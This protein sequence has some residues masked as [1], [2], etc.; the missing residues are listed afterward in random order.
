MA[1]SVL[2]P[3]TSESV[4]KPFRSVVL[5]SYS[6]LSFLDLT[7]IGFESQALWRPIS[8]LQFSRV[9]GIS[10]ESG[11]PCSSERALCL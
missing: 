3:R 1:A 2:E 7:P 6:P 10:C 4:C 5:I 11:R 9:G 8:L